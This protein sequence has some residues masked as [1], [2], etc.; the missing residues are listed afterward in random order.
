MPIEL[1]YALF[2]I[3][4]LAVLLV[5]YKIFRY[6]HYKD[7]V[8]G[9]IPSVTYSMSSSGITSESV[10]SSGSELPSNPELPSASELPVDRQM[11][12]TNIG[13]RE[14]GEMF[15]NRSREQVT[16]N[17][18]YSVLPPLVKDS[19]LII[20]VPFNFDPWRLDKLCEL[21]QS[22][23]KVLD[24]KVIVIPNECRINTLTKEELWKLGLFAI[25]PS[26]VDD[27]ELE[28]FEDNGDIIT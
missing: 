5:Y 3:T 4:V 21:A 20:N 18:T 28:R 7:V 12:L 8:N 6:P 1:I 16:P 13:S 11:L 24:A 2:V 22:S 9:V 19:I 27:D 25:N 17:V 23:A 26:E 10:P 15:F 14:Q